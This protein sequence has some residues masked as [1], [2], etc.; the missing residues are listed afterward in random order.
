MIKV[1]VNKE[2]YYP[3]KAPKIKKVVRDFLKAKRITSDAE[4]SIALVGNTKMLELCKKYLKENELHNVLSFTESEVGQ[5]FIYPPE[6]SIRLGEVVVCYPKAVEEAK[7]E[8]KL[9]DQKVIELIL[10]GTEHL[11]GHHHED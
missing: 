7:K 6:S 5:K 1:Y 9:I 2:S 3:V 8:Q 4:I 10:H 11:L